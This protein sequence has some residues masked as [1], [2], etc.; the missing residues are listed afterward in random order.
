M[1]KNTGL[2]PHSLGV[3]YWCMVN[4][5]NILRID[6]SPW[7]HWTHEDWKKGSEGGPKKESPKNERDW[8]YVGKEIGWAATKGGAKGGFGE[9]RKQREVLKDT[10]DQELPWYKREMEISRKANKTRIA[11]EAARSATIAAIRRGVELG[12]DKDLA[13]FRTA[14]AAA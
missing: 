14:A 13:R 3:Q 9:Y 12:L 4:E 2:T 6:Q 5:A 8:K 1:H 11:K 10:V 7:E